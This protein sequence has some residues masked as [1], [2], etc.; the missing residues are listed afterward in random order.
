[1]S[2]P[3]KLNNNEALE[4]AASIQ[5]STLEIL[6]RLQLDLAETELVA[7]ETQK[8]L[9]DQ[10]EQAKR[11]LQETGRV[12]S[13]VEKSNQLFNKLG[14]LGLRFRTETKARNDIQKIYRPKNTSTTESQQGNRRS[15]TDSRS[16]S[17]VEPKQRSIKSSGKK[18]ITEEVPHRHKTLLEEM[19]DIEGNEHRDELQSLADTD[20]VIDSHLDQIDS[21]L[22][23]L[24]NI[25]RS[26]QDRTEIQSKQLEEIGRCMD[27]IDHE[28]KVVNHR[29][30]RF[31]DGKLRKKCKV[32]DT[33]L[34]SGRKMMLKQDI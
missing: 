15:A 6:E 13:G 4:D 18:R 14:R 29:A 11:I 19:G 24:I 12:Q 26:V 32:Q 21:Q 17:R 20:K 23:G 2:S 8:Q 9:S 10:G 7:F 33:I 22:D 34:S 28:Q 25:S 30:R 1:M 27:E 31:M 5:A 16:E 3:T